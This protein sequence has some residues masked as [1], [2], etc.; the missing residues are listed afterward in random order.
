MEFVV[1]SM[2]HDALRTGKIFGTRSGLV[3]NMQ[4]SGTQGRGFSPGR[5]R[6]NFFRAKIS[7]LPHVADLRHVKEPYKLAWKSQVIG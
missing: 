3:V 6:R 7:R 1:K 4:D 5:S 2:L